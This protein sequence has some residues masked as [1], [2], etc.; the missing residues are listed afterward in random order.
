MNNA[1]KTLKISILG[2]S[3]TVVT[4]ELDVDVLAA[5]STVERHFQEKGKSLPAGQVQQ[6]DNVAVVVALQ[7]AIELVKAE[8]AL[9]Q[10]EISCA[11]LTGMIEQNL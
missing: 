4:D 10:Y 9:K 3:Y 2:K 1:E 11:G 5:V 8:N 6:V 7:I